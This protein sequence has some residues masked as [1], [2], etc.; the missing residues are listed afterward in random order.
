MLDDEGEGG[1]PL[2]T[3]HSSDSPDHV[4]WTFAPDKGLVKFTNVLPLPVAN[5][6]L[7]ILEHIPESKWQDTA[8]DDDVGHNNVSHRFKSVKQHPDLELAFRTLQYLAPVASLV[9]GEEEEEEEE[10]PRQRQQKQHQQPQQQRTWRTQPEEE[11]EQEEDEEPSPASASEEEDVEPDRLPCTFSA[12][13]Y[14]SSSSTTT[15]TTKPTHDH[16]QQ[17]DDRAYSHVL[18]P[19]GSLLLHSRSIAMILYLSKSWSKEWGGLLVD[20][21][22]GKK[23]EYLPEF[24]S[25][26]AFRVPR[27]HKVTEVTEPGKKRYSL[28]GWVLEPGKKYELDM[29]D[30]GDGKYGNQKGG[31]VGLGDGDEREQSSDGASEGEVEESG[32]EIEIEEP[33]KKVKLG[34]GLAMGDRDPQR[35]KQRQRMKKKDNWIVRDLG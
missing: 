32:K 27:W 18:M 29:G 6:L 13:L 16:I 12:A 24:N 35:R 34:L 19:S 31:G 1:H 26:V 22:D 30:Q 14:R 17:H 21:H 7:R 9:E 10:E 15:T 28:F 2:K 25:M 8:A 11:E 4:S 23:V 5:D 20:L 3:D 33:R